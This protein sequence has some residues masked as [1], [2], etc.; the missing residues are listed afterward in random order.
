MSRGTPTRDGRI[1]HRCGVDPNHRAETLTT[2]RRGAFVVNACPAC[3]ANPAVL[4]RAFNTA[5]LDLRD[6]MRRLKGAA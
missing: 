4:D 2:V 6:A 1:E 5:I 3:A